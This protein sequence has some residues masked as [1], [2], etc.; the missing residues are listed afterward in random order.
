MTGRNRTSCL[1]LARQNQ[2]L[3]W[4]DDGVFETR[5]RARTTA[6]VECGPR[7]GLLLVAG[8]P[9]D[10][11]ASNRIKIAWGADV[12]T[13]VCFSVCAQKGSESPF[14][15]VHG[16]ISNFPSRDRNE[17]VSLQSCVCVC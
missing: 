17:S 4:P 2:A 9:Q 11:C 8:T 10:A 14:L 15:I 13:R 1:I 7:R 16:S 3:F 5:M 12:L 6:A